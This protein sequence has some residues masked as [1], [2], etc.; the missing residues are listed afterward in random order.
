MGSNV[1]TALGLREEHG[2]GEGGPEMAYLRA[3]AT[4]S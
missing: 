4:C 2:L 3:L 1:E